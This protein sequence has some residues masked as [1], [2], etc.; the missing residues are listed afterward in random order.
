MNSGES[1]VVGIHC[2]LVRIYNYLGDGHLSLP[3]EDCLPRINLHGR[4]SLTPGW[5][6]GLCK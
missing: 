1:E 5:D 6:P 4:T 3:M 2:H